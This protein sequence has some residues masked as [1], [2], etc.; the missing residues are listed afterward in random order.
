MSQIS[1]IPRKRCTTTNGGFLGRSIRS[2]SSVRSALDGHATA[3]LNVTL[4]RPYVRVAVDYSDGAVNLE[5]SKDLGALQPNE[6]S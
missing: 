6:D 2:R 1:S 5:Q 4:R 3:V